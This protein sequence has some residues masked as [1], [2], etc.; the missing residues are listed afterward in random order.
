MLHGLEPPKISYDSDSLSKTSRTFPKN[1]NYNYSTCIIKPVTSDSTCN[2]LLA[3]PV[4]VN[5]SMV[6]TPIRVYSLV[7]HDHAQTSTSSHRIPDLNQL[8][9]PVYE[10]RMSLGPY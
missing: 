5:W 3:E 7:F 9:S 4:V 6:G 8:V 2:W 10:K 1:L